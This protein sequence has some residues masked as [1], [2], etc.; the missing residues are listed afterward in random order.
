VVGHPKKRSLT[1]LEV[2]IATVL[3]G[4]LLMGLFHS[5]RQS[6]KQNLSARELKQKVLQLELF[7]Q[8]IKNLLAQTGG[9]WIE[10]HPD[11]TGLSLYI[12]FEEKVDSDFDRCGKLRGM[13]YLNNKKEVCFVSWQDSGKDRIE[14]LLDHVDAFKC[15]LFDAKKGAWTES[16]PQKKEESAVMAAID[17]TWNGN[18]I[19]FVFFLKSSNE[20]IS[21]SGIP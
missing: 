14:T 1:L 7:Q 19:P 13:L 2:V 10:K 15:R 9:A 16:W 8:K 20:K 3:L 11:S 6:L 5:F 4:I 17:L 18:K 12:N 21:Y